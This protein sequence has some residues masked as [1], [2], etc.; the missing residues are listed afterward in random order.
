MLTEATGA[1]DGLGTIFIDRV[2]AICSMGID[3]EG[4]ACSSTI[5][6]GSTAGANLGACCWTA[7]KCGFGAGRLS[8]QT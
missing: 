3:R 8:I 4:P 7:A 6:D 2:A 5:E 1:S